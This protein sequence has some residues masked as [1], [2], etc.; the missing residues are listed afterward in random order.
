MRPRC[1]SRPC[2]TA[3][4]LTLFLTLNLALTPDIQVQVA[5]ADVVLLNKMDLAGEE[6]VDRA[7]AHIKAINSRVQILR[8]DHCRLDLSL[9]LDRCAEMWMSHNVSKSVDCVKRLNDAYH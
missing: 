3:P 7:E 8:T 4:H 6:A 2:K 1:N 9:I 5:Y